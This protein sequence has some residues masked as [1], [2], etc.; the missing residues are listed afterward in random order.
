MQNPVGKRLTNT[1]FKESIMNFERYNNC[2]NLTEEKLRAA[3]SN[4]LLKIDKNIPNYSDGFMTSAS[5]DGIYGKIDNV[6]WTSSFWTG[7]LWLAYEFTKKERYKDCAM[8]LMPSYK[9][10]LYNMIN[11]DSHDIGF[12]YT[13]STVAGYKVTGDKELYKISIDAADVL[14]KR[15]RE[16]GKFIQLWGEADVEDK[17]MYRLIIDCLLNIPLLYFAGKAENNAEYTRKAFEHFNT[18]METVVREDGS[19]FQNFYFD[20]VTGERLGGGTKQG[21]S[22]TSCWSRGQAWGVTGT[23][24]TYSYMHNDEIMDK[25]IKIADYYLAHLPED[26][27]PYWD[28]SFTDGDEPR[29]SSAG[30]IAVCGLLEAC[31]VMPLDEEHKKRYYNAACKIME[32]LIDKCSTKNDEKSNGLLFHATY[33][34]AGN[35]GIDECNIWGDYFY[36]EALMRFL[37]PDWKMYW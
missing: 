36:M 5:K 8:G 24:I 21:F 32:A 15:F 17:S 16:K 6:D 22:D 9:N 1:V 33:Y 26:Y 31:R 25:Y 3:L 34:Y 27:I 23:P 37:N 29:D 30:A 19:T 35:L 7:M 18:T 10:R 28:L 20:P 2:G 13:L 4:A 11:M 14:A 12:I